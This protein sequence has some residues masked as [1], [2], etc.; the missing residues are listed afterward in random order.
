M[1][2]PQSQDSDPGQDN[3]TAAKYAFGQQDVLG[4]QLE[5]AAAAYKGG[6]ADLGDLQSNIT[7]FYST[8]G[9]GG[10]AYT[11][12]PTQM[13][14]AQVNL[15]GGD[16]AKGGRGVEGTI[17]DRLGDVNT[18]QSG[19]ADVGYTAGQTGVGGLQRGAGSGL[20]NVFNNLQVST[21]GAELAA[22][23]ADQAL[24]AS[25]DLAAQAGT[26]A[27]GATALAAAAARS[28][29]GIS[30][31]IDRQV[32]ANEMARAQGEQSLQ[33]EL[34]AQGNLASQFDLGQSQFN[35]GAANQAA[36]FGAQARNQANQF[37]AT[38][39]NQFQQQAAQM[40][41]AM[42]QFNLS[43]QNAAFAAET[44]TK[45]N[46]IA[47]NAQTKNNWALQ[48]AGG[49][50]QYQSN[51]WDS[52]MG[53]VELWSTDYQNAK[54]QWAENEGIIGLGA[55]E[56]WNPPQ[57][58]WNMGGGTPQNVNPNHPSNNPGGGAG[59]DDGTE[60]YGSAPTMDYFSSG[61]TG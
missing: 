25:Q 48:K 18:V 32:K 20:T 55:M 53:M 8:M 52:L 58:T 39:Q 60:Q 23:E 13:G 6:M 41:N 44:S 59:S 36:Q 61:P 49:Q 43:N 1:G 54:E 16:P 3:I 51:Q 14:R 9:D 2:K 27:G 5:E 24:A 28:K 31:D 22:Q 17:R 57:E 56:G 26:G 46:V 40:M 35:V 33:R 50:T 30:A 37:N 21:A 45:N 47:Q 7:D 19:L 29:A 11:V 4:A 15:F 10:Q 42:D 34:L 38:T 12:D